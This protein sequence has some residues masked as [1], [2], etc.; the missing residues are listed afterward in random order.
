M[1]FRAKRVDL[2]RCV[3]IACDRS[4]LTM[5]EYSINA[6]R[7][8]RW[9]SKALSS[10][11]ALSYRT[12]RQI[13]NALGLGFIELLAIQDA[14]FKSRN[15]KNLDVD[16]SLCVHIA[17]NKR[18]LFK[19]QASRKVGKARCWMT[20]ALNRGNMSLRVMYLCADAVDMELI[21]LLTICEK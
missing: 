12:M 6:G 1:T 16:F 7:D 17:L 4:G 11:S 8:S 14:N 5:T 19:T 3:Q 2:K 9:I 15:I 10:K 20:H 21:D 18:G 13:C